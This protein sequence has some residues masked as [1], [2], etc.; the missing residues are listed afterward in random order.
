VRRTARAPLLRIAQDDAADDVLGRDPLAL[1]VGMPV[2]RHTCR[3]SS[4]DVCRRAC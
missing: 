3:W 2:D 1:L 4:G